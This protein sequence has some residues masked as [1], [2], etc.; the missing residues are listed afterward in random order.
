MN[1]RGTKQRARALM[2]ERGISYMQALRVLQGDGKGRPAEPEVVRIHGTATS[3]GTYRVRDRE[4]G[5]VGVRVN[6][7]G[8]V[9]LPDLRAAVLPSEEP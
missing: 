2:K 5:V 4:V 6:A 9:T 1:N 8:T 3:D 7:D